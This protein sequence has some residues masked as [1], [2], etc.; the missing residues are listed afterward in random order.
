VAEAPLIV[1]QQL[2]AFPLLGMVEQVFAPGA[3]LQ[4]MDRGIKPFLD[5]RTVEMQ[6]HVARPLN[7]SKIT[8]SIRLPVSIK[9]VAR[10]VRLPPSSTLRAAPKKRS[11][12]KAFDST[13]P[14]IVAFPFDQRIITAREVVMLS[15]KRTTSFFAHQPLGPLAHQLRH[16]HVRTGDSSKV[17]L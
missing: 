16:L 7:S 12:S 15:S 14:D 5:Q 17:E 10:I 8:S 3:R 4:D 9:H 2:H 1:L 13:P 6:L 11:A